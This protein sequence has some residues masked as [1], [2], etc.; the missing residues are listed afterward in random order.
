MLRE[1][2]P[3]FIGAHALECPV[4]GGVALLKQ[5]LMTALVGGDAAIAEHC[6]PMIEASCHN[7]LYMGKIGTVT[8]TKVKMFY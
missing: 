7:V 3:P 6:Q 4:T 2:S 1:E 8:I 5:G